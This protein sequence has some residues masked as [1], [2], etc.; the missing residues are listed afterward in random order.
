MSNYLKHAEREF[1]AAGWVDEDGKFSDDMQE[2]ICKQVIELLKVFDGAGHSGSSAPYALNLFTTL[3]RFDPIGPLTGVDSEWNE[4]GDGVFQN[5]R[6][7]H[8]FKQ[9][10]RFDGQA[11]DLDAIIFYDEYTDEEDGEVHKSYF[12][13]S[14]SRQVVTFP[15]VVDPSK[16]LYVKSDRSG[17]A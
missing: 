17:Q 7:S 14:D 10:D 16:R 9:A 1:K 3:A 11:Y 8:I 5:N 15:H 2:M 6:C 13:S 12:T 4:V